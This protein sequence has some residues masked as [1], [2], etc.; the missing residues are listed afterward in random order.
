M[1]AVL[2]FERVRNESLEIPETALDI[3]V[4]ELAQAA[5]LG[6][7]ASSIE[8]PVLV[9]LTVSPHPPSCHSEGAADRCR[10]GD[11]LVA[12]LLFIFQKSGYHRR[13]P[14]RFPVIGR[15]VHPRDS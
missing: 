15:T 3:F 1:R 10:I 12:A 5:L 9:A 7:S 4:R 2:T 11:I 14:R 8:P 6:P 13:Q